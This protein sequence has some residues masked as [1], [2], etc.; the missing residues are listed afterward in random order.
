MNYTNKFMNKDNDKK[1]K[2]F[3]IMKLFLKM[4]RN[5]V[6]NK[7]ISLVLEKLDAY[8]KNEEKRGVNIFEEKKEKY[9]MQ[10]LKIIQIKKVKMRIML[11]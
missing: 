9:V 5:L 3:S 4:Y 6:F 7:I 10:A 2:T 8:F 11:R 1:N